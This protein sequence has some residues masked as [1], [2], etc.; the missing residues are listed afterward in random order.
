MNLKNI[1]LCSLLLCSMAYADSSQETD[2]LNSDGSEFK[3]P[4]LAG[5][6]LPIAGFTEHTGFKEVQ[7]LNDAFSQG[8][9]KGLIR[10]SGQY[11]DTQLHNAQ[12][13]SGQTNPTAHDDVKQYSA[14]GGYLGYE[15]APW[16]N[17]SVGAT[18]YT[19][20]PLGNNPADRGG[21]GGLD[22]S[23]STGS[24]DSYTVL[25]EA[26]VKFQKMSTF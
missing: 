13:S 20:Q 22:D 9:V 14:I 10:Y 7:N 5:D 21:L 8:K 16:Y 18:F 3:A 26:F 4:R 25:G 11:R 19:S 23:S 17:V 1:A 24:Q 6:S 15:T 12:D 2:E